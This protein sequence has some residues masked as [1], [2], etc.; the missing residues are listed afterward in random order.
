MKE[1]V[2]MWIYVGAHLVSGLDKVVMNVKQIGTL[3]YHIRII[4]H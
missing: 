1:S 2:P 4:L 3:I